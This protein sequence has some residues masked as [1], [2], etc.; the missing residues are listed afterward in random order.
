MPNRKYKL[1]SAIHFG[2]DYILDY[3][4]SLQNPEFVVPIANGM[5][6]ASR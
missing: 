1:L 2:L 3:N 5:F 6:V 4:K